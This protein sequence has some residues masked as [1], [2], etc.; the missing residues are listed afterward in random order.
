[1]G[2]S[3]PPPYVTPTP[4]PPIFK[5][6]NKGTVSHLIFRSPDVIFKDPL[7]KKISGKKIWHF[8]CSL[9]LNRGLYI[10]IQKK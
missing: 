8:I 10:D 5:G 1:M 6:N 9:I 3:L 7:S 2:Y 4:S